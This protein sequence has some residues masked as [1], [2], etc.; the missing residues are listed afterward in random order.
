M[1]AVTW[2]KQAS[3]LPSVGAPP[4]QHTDAAG[5]RAARSRLGFH[6]HELPQNLRVWLVQFSLHCEYRKLSC[7]PSQSH[8][9]VS[10]LSEESAGTLKG[11]Q[12]YSH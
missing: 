12:K 8:Q 7:H 2:E 3:L 11:T 9:Q 6:Q 10:S 5:D 1:A 4:K